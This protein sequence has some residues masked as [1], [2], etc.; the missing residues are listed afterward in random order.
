MQSINNNIFLKLEYDTMK[1]LTKSPGEMLSQYTIYDK[2][3]EDYEY[4]IKDPIEKE[5]FK[6][7]FLIILRKLS[8]TYENVSVINNNKILCAGFD[9]S[10]DGK[11][12]FEKL[13]LN[14]NNDTEYDEIKE[15]IPNKDM[16]SEIRVIQFIV[17]EKLE[18]F[19]DKKDYNGNTILHNL[20]LY[21][22]F[23]RVKKIINN[24]N[25][26]FF[27]TK[28]KNGNT[29]VDLITDIRISNL[30]I[31]EIINNTSLIE[32]DVIVLEEK[33]EKLQTSINILIYSIKFSGIILFIFI[34]YL[35]F[36]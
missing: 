19:Y 2:L 7:K 29:P 1:I 10:N 9:V 18:N 5:D 31:K 15:D 16:P 36:N 27:D 26:L 4:D 22:D 23:E 12:F 6:M 35:L 28:N 30:I 25:I 3:L 8:F 20:I 14:K 24:Q 13:E 33:V 17:D 21:S 34:M 32:G 11:D